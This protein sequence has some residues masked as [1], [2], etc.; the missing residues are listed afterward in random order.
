MMGKTIENPRYNVISVRV[1]DEVKKGI[2]DICERHG[3][4]IAEIMSDAIVLLL[5]YNYM[6]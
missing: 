5:E 1:T 2:D 3:F 4:S 6:K